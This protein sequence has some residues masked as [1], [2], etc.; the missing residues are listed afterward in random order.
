[1]LAGAGDATPE[2]S[3]QD[4]FSRS[5]RPVLLE[6][7]SPCHS[8][9]NAKNRVDFLKALTGKDVEHARGMWRNVAAQLRNRTMP[10]AATKLTEDDRFRISTWIGERLRKTAC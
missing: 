2:N 3:A 5:V 6:H 10:P 8:P 7:C 9:G 4:E 1:M